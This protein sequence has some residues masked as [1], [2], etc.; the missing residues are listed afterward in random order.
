MNGGQH[1]VGL[2]IAVSLLAGCSGKSSA[3]TVNTVMTQVMEPKA[4]AVWDIASKAY[5]DKGDALVAAKLSAAD[6]LEV[7]KAGQQIRDGALAL[8]DAD[9]IVVAG[10]NEPVLGAQAA[11]IK[12]KIGKAWDAASAKQIQ[13]RID[14]NPKLFTQHAKDL[15]DAGATFVQAAANKDVDLFYKVS[16]GLDETCD[17]CHEPFWGTDEPPPFPK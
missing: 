14:A 7:G 15:A 5:N 13:A 1:A 9:R 3:P 2:V 10:K 12:G 8:A 6:W 11:G 16:S 4:Q 17:G